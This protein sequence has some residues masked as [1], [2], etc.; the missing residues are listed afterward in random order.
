MPFRNVG[1]RVLG[2]GRG[3][4]PVVARTGEDIQRVVL[5]FPRQYTFFEPTRYIRPEAAAGEG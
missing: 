2:A 1:L 5:R 4:R 3:W